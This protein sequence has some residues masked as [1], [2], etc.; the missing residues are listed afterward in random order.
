MISW[1]SFWLS[2]NIDYVIYFLHI[3]RCPVVQAYDNK[4]RWLWVR[5][6]LLINKVKCHSTRKTLNSENL[7]VFLDFLYFV[8]E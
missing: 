4:T 5:T 1:Q 7:S 6:Q 8:I 3:S 2:E